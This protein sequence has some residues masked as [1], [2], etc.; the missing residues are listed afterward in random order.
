MALKPFSFEDYRNG[1]NSLGGLY[2]KKKKDLCS[3][4]IE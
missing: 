3:E 4:N 2:L 1:R